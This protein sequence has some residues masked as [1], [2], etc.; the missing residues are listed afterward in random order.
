MR[1]A[2]IACWP[3]GGVAVHDLVRRLVL[4]LSRWYDER[5]ARERDERAQQVIR[6]AIEARQAAEKITGVRLGDRLHRTGRAYR[7]ATFRGH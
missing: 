1:S 4:A 5:E 7:R 3:A 6:R 2:P